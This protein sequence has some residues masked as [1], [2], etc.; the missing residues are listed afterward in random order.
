MGL[1]CGLVQGSREQLEQGS[2]DLIFHIS[3]VTDLLCSLDRSPFLSKF[4]G[5]GN[6][7]FGV[8]LK[9]PRRSNI[10]HLLKLLF[11][12]Q[13]IK[14]LFSKCSTSLL[15]TN[16]RCGFISMSLPGIL[17]RSSFR[18]YFCHS[19]PLWLWTRFFISITL[20]FFICIMRIVTPPLRVIKNKYTTYQGHRWCPVSGSH[21]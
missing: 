16:S 3:F 13:L 11:S 4:C 9:Y 6:E 19:L 1:A 14:Q 5:L 17:G 10:I 18:S 2:W 21:C 20:S 12:C 7:D 15:L 8:D